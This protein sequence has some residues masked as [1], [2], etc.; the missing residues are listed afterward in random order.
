MLCPQPPQFPPVPPVQREHAAQA[1]LLAREVDVADEGR[2]VVAVRPR[3]EAEHQVRHPV[4][5]DVQHPHAALGEQLGQPGLVL[6]KVPSE[7]S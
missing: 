5:I 4:L 6:E 3:A 7:G 2:D 1:G